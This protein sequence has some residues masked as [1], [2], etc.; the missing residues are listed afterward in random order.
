[1]AS[2]KA[3]HRDGTGKGVARQL[4]REQRL[5]AVVYG[6]GKAPQN[7]SLDARE[8]RELLTKEGKNLK[9]HPLTMELLD[10]APELV[11]LRVAQYHPVTSRPLHADFLRFDASRM[12]T[13]SV[14]IR[15]V[16]IEQSP[17]CKRGGVPQLVAHEL[18]LHCRSADVPN[19]ITVSVAGLDIGDSIHARQ[20]VLPAGVVMHLDPAAT[21]VSIVGIKVEAAEA[22]VS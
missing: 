13:V 17:G 12:L 14:V 4:R 10:Q 20:L 6:G 18:E 15:V 8:F 21:V 22:E 9:S 16:G 5:P 19:E 1:M 3:F 2:I 11:L 7:I